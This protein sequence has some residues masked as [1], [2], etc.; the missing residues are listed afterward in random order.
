[1]RWPLRIQLLLPFAAVMLAIMV[2]VTL[3]TAQISVTNAKSRIESRLRDVAAVL[4]SATFPLSDAVLEQMKGLSGA[5]YAVTQDGQLI[6]STLNGLQS[7][8]L[9]SL[10]VTDSIDDLSLAEEI[11]IDDQEYFHAAVA[12]QGRSQPGQVLHMFYPVDSYRKAWSAAAGPPFWIGLVG[13]VVLVLVAFALARTVTAPIAQ[14]RQQVERIAAG[15]ASPIPPRGT[16]DEVR[17]LVD[18]V[19]Q[20]AEQLTAYDEK[21]RTLER[22][23]VLG[24]LGAGFAHQVRN[25]ATG[26]KLALDIHALHCPQAH[27]ESMAIAN[28]QLALITTHLQAIVNFGKEERRDFQPLDLRE[29]V[30][31]ALPLV[32]PLAQHHHV[33]ITFDSDGAFPMQGEPT[34]LQTVIVNLLTNAVEAIAAQPRVNPSVDGEVRVEL[35]QEPRGIRLTVADNGPG[36]PQE[37]AATA[38]DPLI[39]SKREGVGLGLTIVREVARVHHGEATYRRENGETRF[40]IHLSDMRND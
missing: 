20:L 17:D 23:R 7:E 2:G 1:M 24:Q 34:L 35:N 18:A 13:F 3:V 27:D 38:F 6:R 37:I 4:Q 29:V 21:I 22:T 12:L 36:L 19:N 14:L 33:N 31:E 28:Q 39:T 11:S 16:N 10:S 30:L 15:D 9:A 5:Q 8:Q 32:R 40:E 26:C 25:A